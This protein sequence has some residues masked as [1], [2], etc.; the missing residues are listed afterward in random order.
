MLLQC[1]R[2]QQAVTEKGTCPSRCRGAAHTSSLLSLFTTFCILYYTIIF[3]S[4]DQLCYITHFLPTKVF[5][6]GS[7]RKH[8]HR[9]QKTVCVTCCHSILIKPFLEIHFYTYQTMYEPI[10][11][12]Q[13][14]S[15]KKDVMT[16]QLIICSFNYFFKM[17]T[18]MISCDC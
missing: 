3:T 12:T 2:A 4:W 8:H 1:L 16:L 5:L 11:A 13:E 9:R 14:V 15:R 18:Q 6:G 17:L 10:L 7:N